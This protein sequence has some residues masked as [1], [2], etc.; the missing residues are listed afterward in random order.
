MGVVAEVR[1]QA[2]CESESATRLAA[3]RTA[4]LEEAEEEARLAEEAA[5]LVSEDESDAATLISAMIR[6]MWARVE[7]DKLCATYERD[8]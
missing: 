5:L 3:S 6:G 4:A 8:V 1:L 2:A 7:A